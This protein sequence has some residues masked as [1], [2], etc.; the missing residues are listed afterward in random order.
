M[1]FRTTYCIIETN[2]IGDDTLKI[3]DISARPDDS[4]PFAAEYGVL[5]EDFLEHTHTYTELI[6]ILGGSGQHISDYGSFSMKPGTVL[7]VPPPIVHEMRNMKSLSLY[8]LKFDLTQLIA[9]DY[10]LKNDPGFRSL[11]VQ[12][13]VTSQAM[14]NITPLVL[15]AKQLDHVV[16]LME[17]IFQ[18][19]QERKSGYKVMI[20]THLLALTAYLSRCFLPE[21]NALSVQMQKILPTISYMEDHLHQ[22]IRMKELADIV[23]LSTRQYDRIFKEVYGVCPSDYLSELRLNRACQLIASGKYPLGQLW[24]LC[25]FTDN[26]FFYRKFK[27]RFGMTPKQYQTKLLSSMHD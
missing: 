26:P 2:C 7:T 15:E 20:R 27:A 16:R 9:Y 10:D 8:V 22:S 19:F 13:P 17:I 21:Q 6:V 11:F 18:E 25:G 24:E 12:C 4:F 5:E 23:F 14:G 3:Y 1:K